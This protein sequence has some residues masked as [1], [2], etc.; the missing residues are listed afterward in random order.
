MAALDKNG[1]ET[2]LKI[3]GMLKIDPQTIQNRNPY[4][5]AD[6][7]IGKKIT[8]AA[9]V[10]FPQQAALWK[11]E[12]GQGISLGAQA[13]R[14]G[15]IPMTERMNEEL[16]SGIP[17]YADEQAKASAAEQERLLKLFEQKADDLER[18]HIGDRAFEKKLEHKKAQQIQQAQ[19]EEQNRL[20]REMGD[21]IQ[22]NRIRPP[23]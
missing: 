12:V 23:Y 20:W 6:S 9:D 19:Q 22:A 17:G 10:E 3:C 2:L 7:P 5:L 11:Q 15:L 13:A 16:R 4:E 14:D 1:Q 8:M 21:R 18:A